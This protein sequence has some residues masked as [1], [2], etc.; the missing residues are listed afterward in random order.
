MKSKRRRSKHRKGWSQTALWNSLPW[1]R[2]L[3]GVLILYLALQTY[4]WFVI[5]TPGKVF[6]SWNAAILWGVL[7]AIG[8]TPTLEG[9]RVASETAQFFVIPECTIYAPMALFAAGVLV[10]P[11]GILE[12]FRALL[13]G[14]VVLSVLNLIRLLTLYTMLHVYPDPVEAVHVFI[15][16]PVMAT[17]ALVLW[18]LWAAR[19]RR[20]V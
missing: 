19:R 11:S 9:S 15:W 2:A 13:L 14:T 17:S 8:Q 7:R 18:G 6:S 3:V 16:Q 5:S 12:K 10:F 20:Y 4:S 1:R